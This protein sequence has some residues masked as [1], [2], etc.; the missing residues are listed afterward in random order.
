MG[1]RFSGNCLGCVCVCVVT[2]IWCYIRL[3]PPSEITSVL[4]QRNQLSWNE[5]QY[6]KMPITY[7]MKRIKKDT[8][9]E[10]KILPPLSFS[11][12]WYTSLSITPV[13]TSL[14]LSLC[15]LDT[16]VDRLYA[17]VKREVPAL[18]CPNPWLSCH[19]SAVCVSM[20]LLTTCHNY[21]G[22]FSHKCSE[23]LLVNPVEFTHRLPVRDWEVETACWS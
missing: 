8:K 1:Y 17:C 4:I 14:S 6:H 19:V 11:F 12:S 16:V 10:I 23:K 22:T 21:K 13:P 7:T 9:I 2:I 20:C 5:M 18:C 15:F 3:Q